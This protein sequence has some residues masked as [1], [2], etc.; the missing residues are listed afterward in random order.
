MAPAPISHVRYE[1]RARGLI[2]HAFHT[3]P[4]ERA[5]VRSQSLIEPR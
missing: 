3:F 2:V 4:E 5:I 1:A